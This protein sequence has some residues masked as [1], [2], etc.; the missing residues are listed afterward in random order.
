MKGF[1]VAGKVLWSPK[2][3]P[4]SGATIYLNGKVVAKSGA[5][6]VFSLESMRAGTYIMKV[7]AG[8]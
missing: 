8:W 3:K 6:G 1:T 7:E 5:D 2:G 4:M